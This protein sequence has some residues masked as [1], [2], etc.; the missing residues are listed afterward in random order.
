MTYEEV[1]ASVAHGELRSYKQ[2]PQIWY[3]IQ[4]KFAVTSRAQIRP[5]C[6]FASS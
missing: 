3:R 6:A 4:T 1:M 2:L 5:C